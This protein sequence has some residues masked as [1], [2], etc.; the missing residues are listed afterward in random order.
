[1]ITMSRTLS[2][3][4]ALIAFLAVGR[5]QAPKG[6][7]ELPRIPPRSPSDSLKQFEVAPGFRVELT[8]AEPVVQSPMAC[9]W[10]EDGRLYVV[11]L[12]EYNAYAGTRPHGKGRI[13]R[14]EDSKGDGVYDKRTVFA[15]DL[16][17]P[18]G[19][20]CCNGG[21]YVGAAPE[22]LYLKDTKGTGKADVR[23]VVLTGF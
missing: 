9:D 6:D 17:Y 23:Q 14:L 10:D 21:V 1:M 15:E 12:P 22:L 20:I 8:A 16:D 18:T 11:E 7:A 13:V 19:I 4:V 5:G 3:P 2:I